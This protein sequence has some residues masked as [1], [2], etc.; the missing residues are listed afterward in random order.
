MRLRSLLKHILQPPPVWSTVHII[1][2]K[3]L[4][5]WPW[6]WKFS[7]LCEILMSQPWY[8]SPFSK[9]NVLK[10]CSKVLFFLRT[11]SC[12]MA[13]VGTAVG[14]RSG[15]WCWAAFH[16]GSHTQG[17]GDLWLKQRVTQVNKAKQSALVRHQGC[18]PLLHRHTSNSKII[19]SISRRQSGKSQM[20][21][22]S[23]T[24]VIHSQSLLAIYR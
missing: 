7:F 24:D 22:L 10:K 19:G 15:L 18:H 14:N 2:L 16:R 8:T 20:S 9:G 11:T 6:K 23:N 13:R 21:L 12:M 5:F 17:S 4:W 3:E 1:T